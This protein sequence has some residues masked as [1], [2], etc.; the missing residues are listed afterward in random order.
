MLRH[1]CPSQSCADVFAITGEALRAQGVRGV[2]LD[3]DN[4]ITRWS[5]REITSEVQAWVAALA[6]AGVQA[7][8]VSNAIS[9]RRVR[10]VAECLGGIPWVTRA[11]K[12]FARG[13]HQGMQMMG[14]SEE[15]RV[16]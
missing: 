16:G 6:A 12:P 11:G 9:A 2:I 7:C 10:P 4:T 15:R 14:R 3:L 13:Y 8:I 1:L 5:S